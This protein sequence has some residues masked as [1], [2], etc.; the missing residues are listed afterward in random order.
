MA[1]NSFYFWVFFPFIFSSYWLIPTGKHTIKKIFLLI[2][3]YLLYMNWNPIY[4]LVLLGISIVIYYGGRLILKFNKYRKIIIIFIGTVAFA[5]LAVFKY[6]NFICKIISD[7]CAIA[8]A[9]VILPKL[10]WAVPVGISFFTFQATGY[11]LD[12]YHGRIQ[13]EDNFIDL[14][15]FVSFFPQIASGPIS[16]ADELLPQIKTPCPFDYMQGRQGLRQLLWGMFI[17]TVIADRLGLFVDMIYA[18]YNHYSGSTCFTAS[19]FYSLQI[20][21]DFS[22]YSLM[23]TGIAKTLGYN[24]PVNFTR[25]YFAVG[26]ADFWKRWHITLTQW[27]TRQVYIPLGGSRCSNIRHCCNVLITFL[28]SGIWHGANW[29]F[30]IWGVMHGMISVIEKKAKISNVVGSSLW[31][32]T[33]WMLVTFLF[34]NVAWVFFR[35]PS[36]HEA[37]GLIRRFVVTDGT[38]AMAAM[39]KKTFLTI[40]VTLPIFL[41]KEIH[42][43]FFKKSMPWLGAWWARWPMY[44]F[45]FM[46]I[47][48]FGVM[49]SGQFIYVSF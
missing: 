5:P 11:L 28:V 29:T 16:R 41:F 13:A 7:G 9:T 35:M 1:F 15:L 40:L 46:M 30:I 2:A 24:L 39:G 8:G 32:K 20:Y 44:L 42:E 10:H 26:I 36:V 31:K 43:E 17:K 4:A 25:P 12:V 21:C 19:I 23:A 45:L 37:L 22:G 49:D 14:S 18:N 3:S 27:L 34:V 6:Y 47:L 38:G 33:V 48:T